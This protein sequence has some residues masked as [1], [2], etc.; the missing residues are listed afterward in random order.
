[1]NRGECITW[2]VPP[3][4]FQQSQLL[5]TNATNQEPMW[6]MGTTYALGDRVLRQ[7][8]PSTGWMKGVPMLRVF[9][10][11]VASNTADPTAEPAKWKDI[12]PANSVAMFTSRL[13]EQTMRDG[14]LNV[15]VSPGA[16]VTC[17]AFFGLVGDSITLTVRTAAGDV[18]STETKPLIG[19]P[20]VTDWLTFFLAPYEQITQALFIPL[21][22]LPGDKLEVT[23]AGP[24]VACSR[25]SYGQMVD[26]GWG[27]D[28][29]ATWAMDNYT[30]SDPDEFG[31]VDPITRDYAPRNNITFRVDKARIN[32]TLNT[33]IALRGTPC[34]LVGS[35][36]PDYITALVNFGLVRDPSMPIPRATHA[37]M[38]FEFKGFV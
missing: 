19:R 23:I 15:V 4:R 7:A 27:P 17:C 35:R 6:L 11:L 3:V 28:Y 37:D 14:D 29:G 26:L 20:G 9:E 2:V 16:V 30:S 13:A 38:S 33:L 18:R 12:G 8:T 5:S 21:T 22:C 25:M 32:A 24:A 34:L 10:S 36:D 1:M 31:Y